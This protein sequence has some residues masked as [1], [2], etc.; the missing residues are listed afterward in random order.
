MS[1]EKYIIYFLGLIF[2]CFSLPNSVDLSHQLAKLQL[3]E[4]KMKILVPILHPSQVTTIDVSQLHQDSHTRS[5]LVR[6][7]HRACQEMGFFQVI[8]HGISKTVTENALGSLSN[9]FD[10]PMDQKKLFSSDDIS[11]PVRFVT[12][13]RDFIKLYANP[14]ENWIDLWPHNPTEFRENLGRYAAEVKRLSIDIIGAIVESLGLG[15]TY[16]RSSLGQGMQM[17]VGS[18]YPR[19]SSSSSI[20]GTSSHTDHSIITIILESTSGLEIMD[21]ADNNAW[22]SV[23]ATDATLKV[24]VGNHLE[25]LSNGLYKSVFHRV[26]PNPER[27]RISI[28]SFLSLPMEEIMEPAMELI[29]EQHP[30]SYK[31]SSLDEYIKFLSSK[32]E[33]SYIE[34][35]K[36]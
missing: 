8:N 28:G 20:L 24:L 30:K 2:T 34:S 23:P 36:I 7:I 35:L 27:N 15:P 12:N 11:K 16:L 18:R 3:M 4:E 14:I 17:I 25:I 5:V 21:F 19:C 1:T 33:K 32:E 29:D 31:A 10:L 9:F 13:S 22:K 6:S 26:V